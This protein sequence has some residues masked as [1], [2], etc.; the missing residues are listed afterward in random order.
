MESQESGLWHLEEGPRIVL[1][2]LLLKPISF[3]ACIQNI[4]EYFHEYLIFKSIHP[5]WEKLV[6]KMHKSWRQK[7]LGQDS[8]GLKLGENGTNGHTHSADLIKGY[9]FTKKERKTCAQWC[10]EREP[11][12]LWLFSQY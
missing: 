8:G 7:C 12:F 2:V 3:Y 11:S 1:F 4:F 9:G 6:G 10:L 5:K